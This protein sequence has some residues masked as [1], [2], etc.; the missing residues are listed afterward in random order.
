MY[1]SEINYN[2]KSGNLLFSTSPVP[3]VKHESDTKNWKKGSVTMTQWMQEIEK[4]VKF[5]H[6]EFYEVDNFKK[7]KD[8]WINIFEREVEELSK[9]WQSIQEEKKDIENLK[10]KLSIIKSEKWTKESWNPTVHLKNDMPTV[11]MNT[12][13]GPEVSIIEERQET[14]QRNT[15]LSRYRMLFSA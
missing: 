3:P 10:K 7:E 2:T 11:R 5:L 15:S 12:A 4:Y 9:S 6:S 13:M 8:D 14:L 1:D